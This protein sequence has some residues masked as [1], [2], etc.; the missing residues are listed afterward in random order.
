MAALAVEAF[1]SHLCAGFCTADKTDTID[2]F[3]LLLNL[4]IHAAVMWLISGWAHFDKLRL[5]SLLCIYC[6]MTSILHN[7]IDST[8]RWQAALDLTFYHVL[9]RLTET[10]HNFTLTNTHGEDKIEKLKMLQ[11]GHEMFSFVSNSKFAAAVNL[12]TRKSKSIWTVDHIFF[13][14]CFN[15]SCVSLW[16]HCKSMQIQFIISGVKK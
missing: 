6:S 14:M 11:N 16:T 4:Q 12:H 3:I 9:L 7:R 13:S 8:S 15:I 2:C 5:Y 10:Q 1:H